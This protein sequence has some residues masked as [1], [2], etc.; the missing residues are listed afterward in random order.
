MRSIIFLLAAAAA[1]TAQDPRDRK[2]AALGAQLA[3][4][5]R[6]RTTPIENP[7]VQAYVDRIGR[8]LAA[9]DLAYT[10]ALF[11]DDAGGET[12]EPLSL[13]GGYIFVSAGLLRS[14]ASEAELAG[15]LAHAMAHVRLP[16]PQVES[17]TIPIVFMGGWHGLGPGSA[18][19][20]VP[21][22]VL[23]TQRENETRADALAVQRMS[24]AGYDP[25]ALTAYLARVQPSGDRTAKLFAAL[26]DR[27]TRIT[28]LRQAI[29]ELPAR[30][31]PP[32]DPDEFGRMQEQAR[33]TIGS[34]VVPA[35]DRP[36][37]TLRRQN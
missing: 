21:M 28:A 7:A 18:G 9:P 10:F 37:P 3:Q 25:E 13:P 5:V 35:E 8:K 12:H 2:E 33:S 16:R 29:A 4:E 17:A 23:K 20:V 1:A 36:Q 32:T 24:E 14:A 26:P 15:M 6:Q 19:S 31:Y 11:Y 22:S 34:T 27:D 30:S